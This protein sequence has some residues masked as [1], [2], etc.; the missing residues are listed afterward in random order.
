MITYTIVRIKLDVGRPQ[1][2]I[3]IISE[4]LEHRRIYTTDEHIK[5]MQWTIGKPDSYDIS[6]QKPLRR[7]KF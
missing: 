1:D 7:L 2:A 4:M 3:D 5:N 6:E